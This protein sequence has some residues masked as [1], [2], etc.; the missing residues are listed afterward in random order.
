M[1][2]V[3]PKDGD[4]CT[5]LD[6]QHLFSV[7]KHM[8]PILSPCNSDGGEDTTSSRGRLEMQDTPTNRGIPLHHHDSGRDT[9]ISWIGETK[10]DPPS[11]Y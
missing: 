3:I 10:T 4:P 1:Q 2:V 9:C 5:F 8:L 11:N 6:S 7:A